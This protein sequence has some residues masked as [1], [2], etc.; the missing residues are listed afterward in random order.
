MTPTIQAVGPRKRLSKTTALAR[1]ALGVLGATA[2]NDRGTQDVYA[3]PT[4]H[5]PHAGV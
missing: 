1:L 2:T 4:G 5:A 3:P